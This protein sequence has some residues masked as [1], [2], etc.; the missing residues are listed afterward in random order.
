MSVIEETTL[1]L[2]SAGTNNNKFYRVSLD[3]NGIVTKTWG[4]VGATGTTGTENTGKVGYDRVVR[5][6]MRK[7]YK[8]TETVS[9][10]SSKDGQ[11]SSKNGSELKEVAMKALLADA[12]NTILMQLIDTLVAKNNHDILEASGGKMSVNEDGLITTAVGLVSRAN[13]KR[14]RTLLSQLAKSSTETARVE[15]L[16]EYLTLV[17]QKVSARRGWHKDFIS[18]PEEFD[19]QRD[20]LKQLEESLTLHADRKKAAEAALDAD[21]DTQKELADKYADLFKF[22]VSLLED[23]KE[24][25]RINK[26]FEKGKMSVHSSSHLKLK[27]VY[28]LDSPELRKS[29]AKK[30]E[31]V[32]NV[33][34]LWHGTR[35]WNV[36]SILR[37]GLMIS[38]EQLSTV[39]LNGRLYGSGAYF[40]IANGDPNNY[41]KR[42]VEIPGCDSNYVRYG[43]KGVLS[44]RE[45]R[46]RLGL[47]SSSKAL[48]YAFGYWDGRARDN[49]CFMFLADVAMGRPHIAKRGTS[50][51]NN[52][53]Q[54]EN[55]VNS[56]HARGG[57]SGVMND[58]II[59]WDAEQINLK[60]LCEFG[61]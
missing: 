52:H 57:D 28:V 3:E 4:R 48:N 34:E 47:E 2:V 36:L 38:A 25:D 13:V 42:I 54:R 22:K 7:G 37:R 21:G 15:I 24:F 1:V 45:C 59:I 18:Q 35:V 33:R 17:P 16:N 30:S 8:P 55:K 27:R 20:F 49:N 26:L 53:I 58:E 43:S 23:Q 51:S 10:T 56:I 11:A 9:G 41:E 60:Y 44:E 61:P 14:A 40:A 19:K 31:E 12:S 39:Q 32:R 46:R 5:A 50:Y 6:K 29:F